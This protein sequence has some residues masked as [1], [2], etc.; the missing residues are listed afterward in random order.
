MN[1]T[2]T[3]R[4]FGLAVAL[5]AGLSACSSDPDTP[6]NPLTNLVRGK[7]P[8][9]PDPTF[10][11]YQAAGA[12]TLVLALQSRGNASSLFVHQT[13]NAKG[14]ETWISPQKLS[15]AMKNGMIIATRGWGADQL[16]GDPYQTLAALKAGHNGITERFITHLNGESQAETVA[17]RCSVTFQKQAPVDLSSYTASTNLYYEDCRNAQTT[18]RNLFWVERG[19]RKIV[20]SRQWI[21]E[22]LGSVASRVVPN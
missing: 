13:T 16:A 12:P 19:T 7:A 3:L 5:I 18:F 11:A 22:S 9:A 6:T 15:L 20:Q 1:L 4:P 2:T 8:I 17:F 14:E 21:S 10:L